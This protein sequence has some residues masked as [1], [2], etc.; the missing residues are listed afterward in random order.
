VGTAFRKISRAPDLGLYY[1]SK[2][3]LAWVTKY[4]PVEKY[5]KM[6]DIGCAAGEEVG[7]LLEFGYDI[8]GITR[9]QNNVKY[10]SEHF[11]SGK[12]M[13]MDMHNLDF[14]DQSF[15]CIFT[16]H[17]LEHAF[18]LFLVLSEINRVLRNNGVVVA[19]F[20]LYEKDAKADTSHISF[21]HPGLVTA[22]QFKEYIALLGFE[23]IEIPILLVI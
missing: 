9:G 19:V 14:P 3:S 20:P 11:P 8:T 1:N 6:L 12:F 17:T 18:S 10:A 7:A 2:E 16:S 21:H 23:M 22:S 15:D 5:K 13:E 4:I